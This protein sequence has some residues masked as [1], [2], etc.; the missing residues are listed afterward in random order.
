M[1]DDNCHILVLFSLDAPYFTTGEMEDVPSEKISLDWPGCDESY[2]TPK[3]SEMPTDE[4]MVKLVRS[5]LEAL[6]HEKT[7]EMIRYDYLK[8]YRLKWWSLVSMNYFDETLPTLPDGHFQPWDNVEDYFNKH[9]A[10]YFQCTNPDKEDRFLPPSDGIGRYIYRYW[11][12][13]HRGRPPFQRHHFLAAP[14]EFSSGRDTFEKTH[15]LVTDLPYVLA[16]HKSLVCQ[17][18]AT[19]PLPRCPG[20]CDP[21]EPA[22]L[23]RVDYQDEEKR[24]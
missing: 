18:R 17:V 3:V 24:S 1:E 15:H 10:I 22:K 11:L 12:Q 20:S 13:M 21:L 4:V 7:A 9:F 19:H 5:E 23:L 2:L 8:R 6:F 14:I 16:F